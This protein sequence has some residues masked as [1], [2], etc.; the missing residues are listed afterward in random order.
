[1]GPL[2]LGVDRGYGGLNKYGI[3]DWGTESKP[4]LD[5]HAA[6][7]PEH[8]GT[9]GLAG[10]VCKASSVGTF[11]GIDRRPDV[12][13][14]A[15]N[16]LQTPKEHCPVYRGFRPAPESRI[17]FAVQP[18]EPLGRVNWLTNAIGQRFS[19]HAVLNRKDTC[20]K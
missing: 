17:G 14:P 3:V 11:H 5:E 4:G 15:E 9:V 12:N 6:G 1:L 16:C 20:F 13:W 10:E 7:E 18:E 8:L 2:Y 19:T